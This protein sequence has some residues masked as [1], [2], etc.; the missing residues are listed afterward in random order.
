[1]FSSSSS[2]LEQLNLEL[3][4]RIKELENEIKVNNF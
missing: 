3:K 4:F 1:M 2:R